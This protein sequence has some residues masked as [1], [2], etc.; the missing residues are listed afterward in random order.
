MNH[1]MLNAPIAMLGYLPIMSRAIVSTFPKRH[2]FSAVH[3][4]VLVFAMLF[5]LPVHAQ[6]TTTYVASADGTLDSGNTCSN[7]FVRNFSVA[8]NAAITDVDIG[9]YATHSVRGALQMTLQSPQGTR[10]QIVN[11]AF[12]A[13]DNF[14]VRLNDGGTQTVN[15]DGFNTSH[16]T[17][18]P[19]PFQNNFAPNNALSA[20]NGQ[21][22]SGTWRLEIC[23]VPIIFLGGG[24]GDFRH[25][26]LYL[27]T[28]PVNFADLSLAKTLVGNAPANGGN[29][30]YRLT[31]TN[32]SN[33]NRTATGITVRDTFPSQFTFN[34]ATGSGTFN[35][36]T[37]IWTVP[38]L[39]PG[40]SASIDLNG[41]VTATAGTTIT[42][43]AEIISS[44]VADIDSTPNN[45]VTTEDDYAA[46]SFMV[47]EGR[48]AGIAPVLSCPNGSSIFD[49]DSPSVTWTAGSTSNSYALGSFGNIGFNLVNPGVY[50]NNAQFGGQ[51]PILQTTFTGGLSPAQRNLA[52]IVNQENRTASVTVTITLPRSF[53]GVQ[54]RL[55][56]VDFGA[57]QFADRVTV[58]GSNGGTSVTPV[59]TNGN[60]NYVT[61]NTAIGDGVSDN[62]SNAGN[63]VVTFTDRIDRIVITYGN[64]TTA[65]ADPGQQ[66]IGLHDIAYCIPFT[67]L[68]ITKISSVISDPVNG[69]TDPKAIPGA[70]VEYLIT[71]SNTGGD[72]TDTNSVIVTDDAPADAKMCL[73]G[74]GGGSGPVLFNGGSP[75]SGLTYS[76]T[77]LGNNTDDLQFSA[78][79][80]ATWSYVPTADADGCDAAISDFR[81]NP[82]G[83]FAS[84]R[85]FTLRVRFRVE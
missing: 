28:A 56:D 8:S 38:N 22:S 9:I 53:Q 50:L 85:S 76:Y 72:R 79:S 66:G 3:C 49:W 78:D 35:A 68:D 60:A 61:G 51:S 77:A 34:S 80:G 40:A 15:T 23:T 26:E 65:P 41:T 6:T 43:S 37:R 39:A 25:A 84:S 75:A 36:T 64:H 55:F 24:E 29:A 74:F 54:F 1:P 83:A 70:L 33:S 45:G 12:V 19:P 11:S 52:M 71:V 82:K 62:D 69:T 2:V 13:G 81:I 63:V 73:T 47:Q 44:S 16:S 14:N 32:A 10:V 5:A 31:V 57:N 17:A 21:S 42:N 4:L 27:T 48:P 20:F 7:P 59:L 46:T 30:T 18:N 67:T 58:S